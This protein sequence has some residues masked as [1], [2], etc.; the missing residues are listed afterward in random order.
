MLVTLP[1]TTDSDANLEAV[2]DLAFEHELTFYDALYLE[3]ALR[4]VAPLDDDLQR[5]AAARGV[6]LVGA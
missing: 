1:L 6:E 3:L 5:A 4:L 2:L